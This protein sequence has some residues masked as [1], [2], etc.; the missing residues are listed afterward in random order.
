MRVQPGRMEPLGARED[1]T[2]DAGIEFGF[3]DRKW[4]DRVAMQNSPL[5][6]SACPFLSLRPTPYPTSMLKKGL[7]WIIGTS[8]QKLFSC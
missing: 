3:E 1:P 8:E 7:D 5:L 4:E 2:E 6:V